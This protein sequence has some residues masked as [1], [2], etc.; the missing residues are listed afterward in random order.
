MKRLALAL[1]V[2]ALVAC[3]KAEEA[4]PA[5]A[6]AAPAAAAPAMDTS[7]MATDTS[8]GMMK[9]DSTKMAPAAKGE[10]KGGMKKAN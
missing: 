9:A 2:V 4:K 3:K 6:P 7:K 1:S 5:E 10:A 8:K